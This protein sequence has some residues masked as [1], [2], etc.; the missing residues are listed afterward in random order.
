M[1]GTLKATD[2]SNGTRR[3][4]K[5]FDRTSTQQGLHARQLDQSSLLA[6]IYRKIFLQTETLP[7]F[8]RP[9]AGVSS[10]PRDGTGIGVLVCH[11]GS[12]PFGRSLF[13]SSIT[14]CRMVA[15]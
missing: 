6:S 3:I 5:A 10:Q 9:G 1:G 2:I 8:V 12:P 15:R 11:S 7:A 4:Y 13:S 14:I